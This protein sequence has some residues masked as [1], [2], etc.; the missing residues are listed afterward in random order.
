NGF[1]LGEA[2]PCVSPIEVKSRVEER[3]TM[4]QQEMREQRSM[5]GDGVDGAAGVTIAGV[6]FEHHREPIGIGEARPRLSWIVN[7]ATADWRQ[8]GY[9]I[10]AY[11]LDGQFR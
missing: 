9:E 7:T 6:R 4:T 5:P 8:N 3:E 10:E 2:R 11:G 1:Q